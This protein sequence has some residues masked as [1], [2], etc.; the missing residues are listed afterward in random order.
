VAWW[1]RGGSSNA[2]EWDFFV[3]YTDVDYV[4]AEWVAWQLEAAGYRVLLQ[5]WDFVPGAHWS[6][7]MDEGVRHAERTIA[8]LS[9]AYLESVYGHPEWEGAEAVAAPSS[10]TWQHC[11][12][13]AA[14]S[15]FRVPDSPPRSAVSL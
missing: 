1:P 12:G 14:K 3:S 7:R 10:Q 9:T 2:S 11:P 4:W 13:C 5:A 15:G 8:V 6:T